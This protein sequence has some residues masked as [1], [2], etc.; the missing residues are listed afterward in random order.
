MKTRT[1]KGK[2]RT[3]LLVRDTDGKIVRS[4][5]DY[6]GPI[7]PKT[8]EFIN[9][10]VL[11][12]AESGYL[13]PLDPMDAY[14]DIWQGLERKARNPPQ[15]VTASPHTYLCNV[16][17]TMLLNWHK[18]HV[19]PVREE[20]RVLEEMRLGP[21]GACG[22]DD[23]DSD[24]Y[25]PTEGGGEGEDEGGGGGG[26]DGEGEEE[27]AAERPAP[28]RV[29]EARETLAAICA[30]LDEDAVRA[31]SAYVRADGDFRVAAVLV[32]MPQSTFYRRWPGWIRAARAVARCLGQEVR[33]GN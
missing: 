7:E 27:L 19:E 29:R 9:Q 16:A 23:F 6:D 28:A 33:H 14:Q 32:R 18:R 11:E 15:L 8:A 20:Y 26:G 24:N 1:D 4:A 22:I 5:C 10:L 13:Y 31:F 21:K 25:D 17:R 2:P 30:H 3:Q 12:K